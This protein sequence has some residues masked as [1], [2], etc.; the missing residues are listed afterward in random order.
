MFIAWRNLDEPDLFLVDLGNIKKNQFITQ[1][2]NVE[3]NLT[4]L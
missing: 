3:I 2:N 1:A 4:A